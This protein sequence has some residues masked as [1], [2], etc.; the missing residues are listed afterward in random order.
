[1]IYALGEKIIGTQK[2]PSVI[3]PNLGCPKIISVDEILQ[4]KA[5]IDIILADQSGELFYSDDL[6]KD[7]FELVPSFPEDKTN[8]IQLEINGHPEEITE[9]NKLFDFSNLEETQLLIS[10]ELHYN[11]FGE[12][13]KYWLV[14]AVPKASGSEKI[15][16]ETF[17]RQ[18]KN[19]ILLPTLYDLVFTDNSKRKKVNYHAIQFVENFK[20]GFNFIHLTDLHLAQR[21]DEILGEVL[22]ECNKAVRFRDEI[23]ENYIN[24]NDNFRRFI[25][26]ANEL[27]DKGELAFVM[28]TG[29]IVDFVGHGWE[30][31]ISESEN[32]WKIFFNIVTGQ[33]TESNK[34]FQLHDGDN[35]LEIFNRGLRVAIFTSTGNH[36]WR[37]HPYS[38]LPYIP[39]KEGACEKFGLKKEEAENFNYRS[40]DSSEYPADDRKKLADELNK[41]S[42]MRLNMNALDEGWIKDTTKWG[43]RIF[44]DFWGRVLSWQGALAG[45]LGSGGFLSWINSLSDKI[46]IFINPLLIGFIGLIGFFL[47]LTLKWYAERRLRKIIDLLIDNPLHAEVKALHYYF[48]HIN[49]YFD[50][51]FSIGDNHFI[52]MDTG[53]DVVTITAEDL[54]DEKKLEDLK[55]ISIQDNLLGFSPDTMAFDDREAY[56]NWSQIVWL[57]RVLSAA[58]Q[59]AKTGRIILGLHA[60]PVNHDPKCNMDEL[61]EDNKKNGYIPEKT[62]NL[63]YGTINHFLS[64][65]FFLCLGLRE[66]PNRKNLLLSSDLKKV[67]LVLSG[68]VHT[69]AE[70]RLGIEEE[71]KENKIRIYYDKYSRNPEQ[72]DEKKPFLLVTA[73]CGPQYNKDYIT[74]YWRMVRIDGKNR[75]T[76][77]STENLREWLKHDT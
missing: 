32:N 60:P 43:R 20:K 1:M 46:R 34:K 44:D 47:P 29:D 68:H 26:I 22:K 41:E 74:P 77:F 48:T 50:Y 39:G 53:A 63:T 24:F 30:D 71:S 76:S 45:G 9:W 23:K 19:E 65:F 16:Y 36:D 4:G 73:S 18:N 57:D 61:L 69:N 58:S 42:L 64:Q 40:F 62:C 66:N 35:K 2:F 49:P 12:G 14:R 8:H 55:K 5:T 31:N 7:A 37:L 28:I 10:S 52:L 15:G 17:L 25:H 75:I 3:T 59:K 11:V 56:Y 51:A 54:M 21:N 70:Y 6:F 38:L 72:F 27:A 13:T 33:G 67:D